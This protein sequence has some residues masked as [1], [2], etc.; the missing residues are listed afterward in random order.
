MQGSTLHLQFSAA[1]LTQP[2]PT[3]HLLGKSANAPRQLIHPLQQ[4]RD[5]VRPV[6]AANKIGSNRGIDADGC[7]EERHLAS[8]TD[9]LDRRRTAKA[10]LGDTNDWHL[11]S[12][13]KVHSQAR[14]AA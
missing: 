1:R 3:K 12:L 2:D 6:H 14:L 7:H 5:T 9:D 8:A 13:P 4:S 11:L 10:R